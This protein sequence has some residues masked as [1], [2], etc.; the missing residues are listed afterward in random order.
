MCGI[1]GIVNFKKNIMNQNYL[2]DDMV[3]EL[4]GRGPDESR[5]L[6]RRTCKFR[7]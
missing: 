6:F 1:I 3:K 7:S 4:V 2:I 5:N